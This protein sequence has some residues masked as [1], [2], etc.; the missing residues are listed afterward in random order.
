[1]LGFMCIKSIWHLLDNNTTASLC[2]SL[3]ISHIDYCNSLL[4]GVPQSSL[5]KLQWVQNM[6][7]CLVLRKGKMDSTT[8]CLRQLHWLPVRQRIQYKILTL[9]YKSYHQTG[10]KYLQDLIVKKYPK[11]QGL[12]STNNEHL[13]VIPRTKFKTF[14]DRSFVVAAPKLWNEL[15]N[16][17]RASKNLLTF[18]KMLKT[19]LYHQ[20]FN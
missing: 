7:A 18:K 16:N 2:L 10:P 4:Y 13:L 11:C 12:R 6:C 17:I 14:G 3:C 20:A 9:T 8:S 19:Y 1:M 15:P 5:Q